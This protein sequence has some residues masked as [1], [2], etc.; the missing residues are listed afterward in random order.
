MV[1]AQVH[2]NEL[3]IHDN[4]HIIHD[5][6]LIMNSL[7]TTRGTSSGAQIHDNEL[8]IHDNENNN[9]IIMIHNNDLRDERAS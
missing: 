1:R 5:N 8:T 2:D 7:S 4:E 3:T 6:E 9:Y